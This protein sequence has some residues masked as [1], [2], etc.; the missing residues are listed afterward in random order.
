MCPPSWILLL[1]L[2]PPY[3]SRLSQS[4]G[5][6]CPASCN[7]LA[8]VI[9][10]AYG[11]PFSKWTNSLKSLLFLVV[12]DLGI[13][14]D[15]DVLPEVLG[16]LWWPW[17]TL[18]AHACLPNNW[19]ANQRQLWVDQGVTGNKAGAILKCF[20]F[21]IL[22]KYFRLFIWLC[23]FQLRHMGSSIFVV[24]CEPFSWGLWNLVLWPEI[25]PGPP[26]L[27]AQRL[28]CGTTREVP[29]CIWF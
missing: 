1:P 17:P 16:S 26:A 15:K 19:K 20:W 9:Y 23:W 2:S 7:K 29:R 12:S 5:F 14:R 21:N 28:S 13:F 3:P 6:A 18:T 22:K 4:T 11:F 10:F 27:G 24:T 8:V 25:G